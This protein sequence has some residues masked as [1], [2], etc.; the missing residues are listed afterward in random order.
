[1]NKVKFGI[2]LPVWDPTY[3]PYPRPYFSALYHKIKTYNPEL[4]IQTAQEAEKQG[5]DSVWVIDHL[6]NPQANKLLECWTTL[7]YLAAKTTTIRIGTLVLCPLYRHPSLLAKM[8]STLDILSNGRLELG[9]GSCAP[10]NRHEAKPR[11]MRWTNIGNRFQILEETIQICKEVWTKD[12][13]NFSGKH[14]QL[15]D[16]ACEPKPVQ[17]PH[18]PILIAGTGEK[19]TL[20]LVAKYAD[21]SNFGFVPL[22]MIEQRLEVLRNHCVDVGRDYDS[23]EK[24]A[25]IGVIVHSDRDVY[26]ED[27]RERF[28][29]NVG[30]GSFE[31]WLVGAEDFWVAGTPEDCVEKLQRYVDL[32]ISHFMI[33]FGDLPDLEAVR[34]FSK[35][36]IPKI[37]Q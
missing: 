7:S 1:M 19:V 6:S 25:E 4:P 30:V 11:G 8:A 21:K 35:K 23:V 5:Y 2:Q 29:V 32:G 10:T 28:R 16:L 3:R 33:R 17:K 15:K 24:T 31:E 34:L 26:L 36:V 14:F 13:A 20:K 27:M 22:D 18:P 37:N 9:L 12:R